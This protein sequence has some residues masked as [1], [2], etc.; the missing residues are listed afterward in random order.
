M[1]CDSYATSAYPS[2]ALPSYIAKPNAIA[3]GPIEATTDNVESSESTQF[4]ALALGEVCGRVIVGCLEATTSGRDGR[5]KKRHV[6][7]I[8]LS[9]KSDFGKTGQYIAR[10]TGRD[11]KVQFARE[12][13]GTKSGKRNDWTS[14]ETD[15]TGVFEI[16]DETRKGRDR[17]YV[18][19]VEWNDDLHKFTSDKEDALAICKRLQTGESFDEMIAVEREPMVRTEVHQVCPD[20]DRQMT[21]A[22]GFQCS[23]HPHAKGH[24]R[25]VNVDVPVVNDD[26]SPRYRLV[27]SIRKPAEVKK[28]TSAATVDVAVQIIVRA[29]A[30]LSAADQK[31]ALTMAR[32]QLFPKSEVA[33]AMSSKD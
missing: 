19:V 23:E 10:L 12:F 30:D 13:V 11:K 7:T 31:K 17:S 28:A 9:A 27:Y 22:N 3:L 16:N 14:F 2:S 21:P 33:G 32:A 29:L 6:A 26:G 4:R 20:C 8:T 5:R 1:S 24:P 18:L 15:E 25:Y